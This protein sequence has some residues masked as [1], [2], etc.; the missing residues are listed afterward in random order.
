MLV[1]SYNVIL[2]TTVQLK[3]TLY[4]QFCI[5]FVQLSFLTKFAEKTHFFCA[6]NMLAVLASE[7]S[8]VIQF[9]LTQFFCYISP[10][11]QAAVEVKI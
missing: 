2:I 11:E 10:E 4:F 9:G 5:V 1:V 6:L 8:A 3:I 7:T